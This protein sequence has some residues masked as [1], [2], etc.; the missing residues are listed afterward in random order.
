MQCP[1]PR[2]SGSTRVVETFP[3]VE[4]HHRLRV[5]KACGLKFLTREEEVPMGRIR[6][7][8]HDKAVR[9]GRRE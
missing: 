4:E 5:C 9:Q 7:L 1:S 8:R 6:Q 2:C 3:D